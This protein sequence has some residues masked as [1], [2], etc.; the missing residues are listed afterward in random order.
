MITYL[1]EAIGLDP[2]L[3]STDFG[4]FAGTLLVTI[5]FFGIC[6]L[7]FLIFESFFGGYH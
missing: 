2:D 4:L 1:I 6:K 7:L 3:I 5:A